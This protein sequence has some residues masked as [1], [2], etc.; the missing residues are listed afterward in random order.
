MVK[1]KLSFDVL[2]FFSK[3]S[4]TLPYLRTISDISDSFPPRSWNCDSF[5]HLGMHWFLKHLLAS[6]YALG[7]LLDARDTGV[8][9]MHVFL[10]S[11]KL[12]SSWK[13]QPSKEGSPFYANVRAKEV[14]V[15]WVRSGILGANLEEVL[16]KPRFEG[17]LRVREK[18]SSGWG[19]GMG[20][21]KCEITTFP[22]SKIGRCSWT[23]KSK[24]ETSANYLIFDS[25]LKHIE[26]WSAW[27]F[28]PNE[29]RRGRT[30]IPHVLRC[31]SF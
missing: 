13:R 26:A 25:L 29:T 28:R 30:G 15:L 1:E 7:T 31:G 27:T 9:G 22:G 14:Q 11:Q 10:P 19:E 4:I 18:M 20:W 6:I 5:L 23:K 21:M 3:C 2:W 12:T 8:N 16:F 17:N 24:Q